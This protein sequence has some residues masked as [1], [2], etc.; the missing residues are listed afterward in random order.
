[1]WGV[2]TV[3]PDATPGPHPRTRTGGS[4]W[5]AWEGR[6]TP[7][8]FSGT[9]VWYKIQDGEDEDVTHRAPLSEWERHFTSAS[10]TKEI[11]PYTPPLQ[12]VCHPRFIY[13]RRRDPV[14]SPSRQ[15][16]LTPVEEPRPSLQVGLNRGKIG[17][18]TVSP[19][20]GL[21]GRSH[22]PVPPRGSPRTGSPVVPTVPPLPVG[23]AGHGL[24]EE[25][26]ES[27]GVLPGRVAAPEGLRRE[28]FPET[29]GTTH[30]TVPLAG[31]T[32]R[33]RT[34]D[35]EVGVTRVDLNVP[36]HARVI[37]IG[38][39][40]TVGHARRVARVVVRL[41]LTLRPGPD[42]PGADPRREVR[43]R[44][45]AVDVV[46]EA[47]DVVEVAGGVVPAPADSRRPGGRADLSSPR[48]GQ[49]TSRVKR[50]DTSSFRSL[51]GPLDRKTPLGR[52]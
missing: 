19:G 7:L 25:A 31:Q 35:E 48:P 37:R 17:V 12:T 6:P 40:P 18:S 24:R 34:V 38:L 44:A 9:P 26:E 50:D 46:A 5:S 2:G 21:P 13:D 28:A 27:P 49:G 43:G 3:G 41:G 52:R 14:L 29:L 47:V 11:R 36:L 1:M 30:E 32:T 20:S 4:L 45:L 16:L 23:A 8:Q 42:A 33:G 51:Q 15:C 10:T 39:S 22:V